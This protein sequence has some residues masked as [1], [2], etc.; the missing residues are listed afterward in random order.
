MIRLR[1]L[2]TVDLRD[3][4]GG[5]LGA[6]L[7]RPKLLA[8]L[9]YL[10]IARPPGFHR[11][12][13][14]LA[15]LWPDLDTA[16]ARNALRQ[17]LH[18]LR[19]ALGRDVVLAR[20][21]EELGLSEQQVWCDVREFETSLNAQH[22]ERALE[23]FQGGLLRGLHVSGAPEFERWLDE[24]REHLQQRACEAARRL[25]DEAAAAGDTTRAARWARRLTELSPADEPAAQR[26]IEFLDRAGDRPGA[27]R[28]YEEFERRLHRDLELRPDEQTRALAD[29]VRTRQRPPGPSRPVPVD[30]ASGGVPG[31]PGTIPKAAR[32]RVAVALAL[33][34]GGAIAGG[35]LVWPLLGNRSGAGDRNLKRLVVLPFTNL[36]P[37]ED[38]YFADGISEEIATRLAAVGRVRVIGS[39]SANAY[40]GIRKTVPEIGAE[41]HVDYVVEGSIRWQK[42]RHGPARVRVTLQLLSTQ[43]GA[44]VW[45]HVYDEPLDEIFR[46]QSDIAQHVVQALDVT[47]LEPER[48][49]IEAKPTGNLLAY[50]YYL[51]ANDYMRRGPEE[52]VTR[53]GLRMFEKAVELD[54]AFA[55]AWARLSQM[56]SRMFWFYY[57]HS[58]ERLTKAKKAVDHAFGVD[59]DLP[60]A[61]IALGT[62]Y[63]LG[64]LEYERALRE[65]DAAAVRRPNSSEIFLDRAAVRNRQ[66]N[67]RDGLV[68]YQ[69]AF[70]LDPGST[71]IANNYAQTY[72]RLRDFVHAEAIYDRTIALSPDWAFTYYCKAG[73]YLRW[74][75][76]TAK[77]RAAL[78]EARAVGAAEQPQVLFARVLVEVFDRRYDEA[79]GL[80]SSKVPPVIIDQ[81]RVVP[82]AQL[83]AQVYGLMQRHDLERAY[84][85]SARAFVLTKLREEPDD[86][87]LHSAL[88]IAY[89]GLGQTQEAI[90]E[91][92]RAVE[93][94]PVSKEAYRGYAR[95]W[96]LA[97]IYT[98]VGNHDAAVAALE[99]LLSDPGHLTVAWLRID[100]TW[101]P[102]RQ[103]PRFQR[104]VGGGT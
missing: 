14:L 64:R 76:S 98:M 40:K 53:A 45:A 65:Y 26:L 8:L 44:H 9:A 77:A 95:A 99:R 94:M 48:R 90:R 28:A 74:Q 15:L 35:V 32:S 36:G 12:D 85:D 7:R 5:E 58:E 59:A 79:I 49:L 6:V 19:E 52:R 81:F 82:R 42:A 25:S 50:D 61:H 60:E 63:F 4:Q 47:L 54:S 2:G 43:D 80:L 37:A 34:L 27:V 97:Q 56:H 29:A 30:T 13:S 83:Y 62:F 1:T 33:I 24:E 102:L 96:D 31:A 88:G 71:I 68:N 78:E 89:A 75:G 101:D 92:E 104:I 3:G 69:R 23:L 73:L 103:T 55:P 10:A 57:D 20:G 84:Y 21:E 87:R 22:A 16:H 70:E 46:V 93:L 17:A 38:E 39:T 100:P 91:G 72:D 11:R 67:V 66:G 86:P 51:R 18:S 41:L